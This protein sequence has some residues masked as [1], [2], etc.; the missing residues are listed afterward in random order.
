MIAGI[1]LREGGELVVLFPIELTTVNDDT[2]KA[3]A[4]TT[5]EL[6]S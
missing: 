3:C 4:V 2:T 5:E 6:G 1:W